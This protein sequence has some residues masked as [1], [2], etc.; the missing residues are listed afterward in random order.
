MPIPCPGPGTIKFTD[1]QTEFGGANPLNF[2]EY[3]RNG[4]LV[5]SNNT[6][7]PTSGRISLSNFFCSSNIITVIISQNSVNVNA[8]TLFGSFWSA[9]RQKVLIV[10]PNVVVGSS[11]ENNWGLTIPAGLGGS[12]TLYNYGY[13]VGS[14]GAGGSRN[15]NPG[16]RGGNAILLNS[17]MNILNYGVIGGGGGGG[18]GGYDVSNTWTQCANCACTKTRTIT[19]FALGGGGG[20]GGGYVLGPGGSGANNGNSGGIVGG[21]AGGSGYCSGRACSVGGGGGG[22]IGYG[23]GSSG[24]SGGAPG[25]SIYR[26]SQSIT[27]NYNTTLGGYATGYLRGLV[28]QN[29]VS[30]ISANNFQFAGGTV[31]QTAYFGPYGSTTYIG[32]C[33][34]PFNPYSSPEIFVPGGSGVGFSVVVVASYVITSSGNPSYS[35]YGNTGYGNPIYRI[36][37]YYCTWNYIYTIYI[38][39]NGYNYQS[40][41]FLTFSWDGRTFAFNPIIGVI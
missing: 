26:T 21:G 39:Q 28:N 9:N 14:G 41:D 38:S 20:G 27:I 34:A 23:G 5:S 16:N 15:S 35:Y 18:G 1:I 30:N 40:N 10:N 17:N 24:G 25:L 32:N 4:G 12:L 13:I 2:T 29:Y 7:V 11:D 33:G 37:G 8:A 36:T 19:D 31:G 3:Y 6:N 22:S